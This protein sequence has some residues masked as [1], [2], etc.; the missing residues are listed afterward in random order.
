MSRP[1]ERGFTLIEAIVALAIVGCAGVAALEAVGAE[2]RGAERARE[3]YHV[4]ALAQDRLTAIAVV[5]AAQLDLL[6]D[7]L[8]SGA[9]PVPFEAY[10]WTITA[11]QSLE[12]ADL[13]HVQLEIHGSRSHYGVE[14]LL[15]RPRPS[16]GA[17]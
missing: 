3:A 4:A 8:A 11:R 14:T 2:V 15:Y 5:P 16:S 6:P 13:Y 9:F 1:A 17:P 12:E 7:S 10:G